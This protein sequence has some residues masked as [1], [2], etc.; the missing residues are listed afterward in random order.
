MSLNG[1]PR[2]ILSF[3]FSFFIAQM[4]KTSNKI[5]RHLAFQQPPPSFQKFITKSEFIAS[6]MLVR[7]LATL[8][9]FQIF[10][11]LT[12]ISQGTNSNA[13]IKCNDIENGIR[14]AFHLDTMLQVFKDH[15]V[16]ASLTV[17]GRWIFWLCFSTVFPLQWNDSHTFRIAQQ[18]EWKMQ[19]MRINALLLLHL[20]LQKTI[21]S[22]RTKWF[23]SRSVL[24]PSPQ[25]ALRKLNKEFKA[26]KVTKIYAPFRFPITIL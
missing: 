13:I 9:I 11:L 6:T 16:F 20:Q 2:F 4:A 7:S 26:R 23:L 18:T 19:L 22:N 17:P 25:G 14:R 8:T 21:T 12:V 1:C 15:R 10:Y 3:S 24:L 5:A